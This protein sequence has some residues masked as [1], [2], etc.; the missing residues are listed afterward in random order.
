MAMTTAM[1]QVA[2]AAVAS[3]WRLFHQS[4]TAVDGSTMASASAATDRPANVVAASVV[5]PKRQPV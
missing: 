4:A 3:R 1:A 2:Y 5:V